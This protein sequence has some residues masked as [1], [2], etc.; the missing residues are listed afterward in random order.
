MTPFA[1]QNWENFFNFKMTS[2]ADDNS[3]CFNFLYFQSKY[4]SK[5]EQCI[6][7]R[8]RQ[9]LYVT[10]VRMRAFIGIRMILKNSYVDT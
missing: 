10:Y 9:F 2:Q 6:S 8:V 1:P 5:E 4:L 3:K 7:F